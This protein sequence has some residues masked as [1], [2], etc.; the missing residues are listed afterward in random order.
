M[1]SDFEEQPADSAD[2]K[3]EEKE[4]ETVGVG[5]E[6]EEPETLRNA[7]KDEKLEKNEDNDFNIKGIQ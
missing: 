7:D 5:A 2:R 6:K 1:S 3:V 4:S